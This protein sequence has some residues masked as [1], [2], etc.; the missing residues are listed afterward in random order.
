MGISEVAAGT[1]D[2]LLQRIASLHSHPVGKLLFSFRQAR[3]IACDRGQSMVEV[4]LLLPLLVFVLLGGADLA[5]AYAVQ[6]AVQNGARAGA[7][8][9]ALDVTPTSV[10]ALMHA[11][12]EM[13]RTPGMNAAAAIVSVSF[14]QVDGILPCVGAANTTIA[15]TS[16][17][18]IPCY[19]NVRVQYTFRTITPWPLI[20]NVT[21]F[22]RSTMYRRYQ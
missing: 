8:A 10:E 13:N 6:L 4:A 20:P 3:F 9:T 18:A 5:R 11:Q 1:Q 19:A 16:T 7:E 17:Y 21:T 22:D 14:T 12:Q 15:G 2:L